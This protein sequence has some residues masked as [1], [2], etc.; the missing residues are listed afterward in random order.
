M[1]EYNSR[2]ISLIDLLRNICTKYGRSIH[3]H[4]NVDATL[5]CGSYVTSATIPVG[6]F[7]SV[8]E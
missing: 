8:N 2:N 6:E 5:A 7:Y 3:T 4:I 1:Q